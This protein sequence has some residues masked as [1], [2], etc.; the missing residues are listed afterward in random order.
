MRIRAVMAALAIACV[1]AHASAQHKAGPP[2]FDNARYG[3]DYSYLR[4]PANWTGA[5]WEPYK[6]IRLDPGGTRYLTLGA[7]LRL[8]H[9]RY[10]DKNW[11]DPPEP[12]DGCG[13]LR[14]MPYADLHLG[15]SVRLFGQLIG[16]WAADME[17][18]PSPA[19]ET[20]ADVL[21][22]FGQLRLPGV[23]RTMTLQGGRQLLAYGSHRLIGLRFGPNVPR[24]FDGGLV[25]VETG[26]WRADAL[27]MRPVENRLHGF[28]DRTDDTRK[29]WSLYATRSL[30]GIGASSGLDLFYIGFADAEAE[31]EQG[32]GSEERHTLG[33]RFFGSSGNWTWD[34]EG[35]VQFGTFADG[36]IL[37]WSADSA[38]RYTLSELPLKPYIELRANAISGDRDPDNP[39]LDSFNAMFPKGEYFGEI[40]LI[41]P[42]NLLNLHPIVG[43]YL[44]QGW[45]LHGAAV[46]YWR[47]STGDGVYDVPG[48][49][50][51]ASGDSRARYIGTQGDIVL[52]WSPAR[53]ID[54]EIVYS[55]FEPG[56]FIEETG[57]S[58]T[59][60][61]GGAEM[62]LRF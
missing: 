21:Q 16:A 6:S 37:A 10:V 14:V 25:R 42:R 11:G 4:N 34:V 43:V 26:P 61:F 18:A 35:H 8:R 51:R 32:L 39:Q 44:G 52:G 22:A 36:S 23:A 27:F 58:E 45:S 20:G 57:P 59:V 1:P 49:L 46:L 9:E 40:G 50:I 53:G 13:W 38:T 30:A 5:W 7:D 24:A 19:D 15:R 29:L 41:G 17:P 55:M 62:Q 47:Q 28:D 2:Q 12:T 31:Y 56:P 3:E 33:T 54:L 48:N 60:Y